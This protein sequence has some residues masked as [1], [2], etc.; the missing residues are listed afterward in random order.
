MRTSHS[1]ASNSHIKLS[2]P[3]FNHFREN[4]FTNWCRAKMGSMLVST[5]YDE[6][7]KQSSRC[8]S[9]PHHIHFYFYSQMMKVRRPYEVD[10][11]AKKETIMT[12][13]TTM[14]R[15]NE[16][17]CNMQEW[18]KQQV[19]CSSCRFQYETN[20]FLPFITIRSMR[21]FCSCMI[22]WNANFHPFKSVT[23]L[24][25]MSFSHTR[26]HPHILTSIFLNCSLWKWIMKLIWNKD[27]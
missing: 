1:H 24:L 6:H 14:E 22:S 7:F 17:W 16:W 27:N 8:A 11:K 19:L 25:H 15:D 26:S 13:T 2:F 10:K 23:W 20:C 21:R 4:L 12:T 18:F 9:F 5:N 3:F